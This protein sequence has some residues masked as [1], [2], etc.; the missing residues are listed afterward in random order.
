MPKDVEPLA[1]A[2]LAHLEEEAKMAYVTSFERLGI[3]K[4]R[5]EGW[6]RGREEGIKE[7]LSTNGGNGDC[8]V[9]TQAQIQA[10]YTRNRAA[11][12]YFNPNATGEPNRPFI[13]FFHPC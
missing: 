10:I 5:K 2:R 4:G 1:Q 8:A 7:E 13:E 12:W 9:A 3:E 6:E 11:N